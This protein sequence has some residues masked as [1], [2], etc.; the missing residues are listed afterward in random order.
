M[1][2]KTSLLNKDEPKNFYFL[3]KEEVTCF[4]VMWE[5][6]FDFDLFDRLQRMPQ[7]KMDMKIMNKATV[8]VI[9]RAGL[10]PSFTEVSLSLPLQQN[11]EK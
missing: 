5:F 4:F 6:L 8:W 9:L 7:T 2:E 1:S 3:N 11:S 10:V